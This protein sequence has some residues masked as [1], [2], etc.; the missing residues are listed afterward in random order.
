MTQ[1]NSSMNEQHDPNDRGYQQEPAS[2]QQNARF[3]Q[4]SRRDFGTDEGLNPHGYESCSGQ[5]YESWYENDH[6]YL[7][8][9]HHL[10]E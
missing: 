2:E 1:L 8:D 4:V 5:E 7:N 6:N 9:Q 3:L 10:N